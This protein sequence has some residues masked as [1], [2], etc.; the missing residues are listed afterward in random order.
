MPLFGNRIVVATA[1]YKHIKEKKKE[2]FE[3]ETSLGKWVSERSIRRQK[4]RELNE[5][6]RSRQNSL[7]PDQPQMQEV[8]DNQENQEVIEEVEHEQKIPDTQ[9]IVEESESPNKSSSCGPQCSLQ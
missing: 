1:N 8:Q 9:F 3:R 6:I 2:F 7:C 4:L 5:K